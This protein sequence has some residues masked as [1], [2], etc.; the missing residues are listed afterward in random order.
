MFLGPDL[1]CHKRHRRVN[2]IA[3]SLSACRSACP[4]VRPSVRPPVR[5]PVRLSIC[6]PTHLSVC[7]PMVMEPVLFVSA[8]PVIVYLPFRLADCGEVGV[9]CWEFRPSF[10]VANTEYI[11]TQCLDKGLC[12]G[13]CCR[14]LCLQYSGS[15]NWC[16]RIN[17]TLHD[18]NTWT[19]VTLSL[20]LKF[21]VT[22]C[23]QCMMG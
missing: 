1:L 9:Y 17:F 4:P 7:P 14:L 22:A 16:F 2:I 21:C 6:P 18:N 5:P 10:L 12:A 3:I 20:L 8:D 11:V 23:V 15:D 19:S 13:Q